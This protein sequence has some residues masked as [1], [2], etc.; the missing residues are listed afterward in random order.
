MSAEQWSAR[1]GCG[2]PLRAV[3]CLAHGN[4]VLHRAL[5]KVEIR[6][7]YPVGTAGMRS[8]ELPAIPW[9]FK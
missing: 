8:D 7:G 9:I 1:K 6:K 4:D 3:H 5:I 2:P